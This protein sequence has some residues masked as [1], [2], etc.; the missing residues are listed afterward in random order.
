[1]S[2]PYLWIVLDAPTEALQAR[3]QEVAFEVARQRE[4]YVDLARQFPNAVM[5]G[6]AKPLH[7]VGAATSEATFDYMAKRAAKQ[8]SV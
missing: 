1:M 2:K 8:L 6:T 3:K 5:I 7:D 4:A